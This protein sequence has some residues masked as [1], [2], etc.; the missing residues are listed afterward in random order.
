MGNKERLLSNIRIFTSLVLALSMAYFV[1]TTSK[2][3]AEGIFIILEE[4]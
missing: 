2:V 1:H 3:I 4:K